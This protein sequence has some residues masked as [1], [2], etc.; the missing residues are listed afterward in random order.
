MTAGADHHLEACVSTPIAE[1]FEPAEFVRRHIGPSPADMAHM[2]DAIGVANADELLDQTV[3]DSI[4]ST[5][6]LDLPPA[7]PEHEAIDR[8]RL[9][10]KQ[11]TVV[12]SLIGMVYH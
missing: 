12:T 10:A 4:R 8:L 5:E 11:N 3:P 9:I 6:P 2:L 1:L 7:V